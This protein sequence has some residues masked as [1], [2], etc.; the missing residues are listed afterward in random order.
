MFAITKYFTIFALPNLFVSSVNHRI[1]RKLN[2]HRRSFLYSYSTAMSGFGDFEKATLSL[3][4]ILTKIKFFTNAKPS[5]KFSTAEREYAATNALPSDRAQTIQLNQPTEKKE[6]RKATLLPAIGLLFR[7]FYRDVRC[8]PAQVAQNCIQ[9]LWHRDTIRPDQ[10][11]GFLCQRT[12]LCTGISVPN[13]ANPP[14]SAKGS[15]YGHC[16]RLH[17]FPFINY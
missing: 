12:D 7:E 16:L 5:K 3:Y 11:Q 6:L 14:V 9:R 4:P 1:Y 13:G 10:W 8:L 2:T 15:L 17:L